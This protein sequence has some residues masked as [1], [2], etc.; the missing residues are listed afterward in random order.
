MES[1]WSIIPVLLWAAGA[2]SPC[3]LL[4]G[5]DR[6]R[7]EAYRQQDRAA[8]SALYTADSAEGSADLARLDEY[9]QRRVMVRDLR[10]ER[11]ACIA[12]EPGRVLAT[13]RLLSATAVLPDGSE[14]TLPGGQWSD[15]LIRLDFSGGRWRIAEVV[16]SVP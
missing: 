1:L 12:M 8:L 14:R 11:R 4:D 16:E 13:E 15:R 2:G 5:L 10:V 7:A 9:R 6:E 3:Q